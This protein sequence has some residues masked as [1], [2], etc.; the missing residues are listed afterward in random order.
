MGRN[1]SGVRGIRLKDDKD[2]VVGMIC[3][4][5]MDSDILVV[6]ENGYGKRSSLEDYRITNRGG[7]GVKT[8]SITEKT[9][10]LVSIKNVS[11]SDDLMIINKSGIAIRMEVSSL[12]VMG[13]ATQGVKLIN[14]KDSD[15]IAAVAKVVNND[16]DVPDLEE[17][18]VADENS[19][20]SEEGSNEENNEENN[21]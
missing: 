10:E 2:S 14:L 16:E 4:N 9:G 6:S 8:I 20:V 15:S 11:D 19:G 5:D 1:A 18:E 13:R 17:I 12:R 3:V 21:T 7:K